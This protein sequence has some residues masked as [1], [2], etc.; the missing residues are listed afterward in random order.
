MQRDITVTVEFIR[1]LVIFSQSLWNVI[2][3][4][5]KAH[6]MLGY[7]VRQTKY[8]VRCKFLN[9]SHIVIDFHLRTVLLKL[10]EINH[11]I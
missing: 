9:I 5:I 3:D 2:G 1:T 10:L 6:Y 4:L 8:F 7:N 11:K